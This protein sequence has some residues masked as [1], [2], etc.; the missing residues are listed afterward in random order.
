MNERARV[1]F[2]MPSNHFLSESDYLSELCLLV[3]K[4]FLNGVKNETQLCRLWFM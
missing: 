1:Q 3:V 4:R 2:K